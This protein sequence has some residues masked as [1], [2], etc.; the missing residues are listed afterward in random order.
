[1]SKT[2]IAVFTEHN[3]EEWRFSLV[4]SG[5]WS[6]PENQRKFTAALAQKM[7]FR[8]PEDWYKL[9]KQ[10]IIDCGGRGLLDHFRSSPRLF[11][12]SMFPGHDWK[13]WKFAAGGR[14]V[15]SA[16]ASRREFF[17]WAQSELGLK[18]LD[19]WYS[20]PAEDVHS[21]GGSSLLGGSKARRSLA[22]ALMEA[23]PDHQWD[24]NSFLLRGHGVAVTTTF[25]QRKWFD[26]AFEAMYSEAPS[27]GNLAN[28][29]IAETAAL[30]RMA[31]SGFISHSYAPN[32]LISLID[33]LYSL[34]SPPLW[35][36]SRPTQRGDCR[37]LPR[38]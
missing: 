37:L 6:R 19:G 16:S 1:M 10:D 8:Q 4:P 33:F 23:Y 20:V 38:A 35:Q 29:Y 9:R 36:I 34:P 3:W 22:A 2:L 26:A 21:L 15:W 14:S 31:N 5:F 7:N 30:M 25:D 17:D 28:W 24:R 11:V 13:Q 18:A 12:S 32:P 27:Q